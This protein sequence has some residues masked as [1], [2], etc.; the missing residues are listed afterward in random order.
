MKKW[1]IFASIILSLI[2]LFL[3]VYPNIEIQT[4]DQLIAFRYSDDIDEFETDITDD[5]CYVYY[6]KRDISIFNYD[7][8]KFWFF[9]VITMDYVK[10]NMCEKEYVLEEEYIQKFIENAVIEENEANIDVAELIKGKKAIV[11]NTRYSGNEYDQSIWYVLDGREEV[12]YVF[13]V[14]DMVVFQV[15]LS[16]EGPKFIAYK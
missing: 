6:G 15:G 7:F 4:D 3:I 9:H 2:V 12:M 5:E 10:G 16:D 1:I 14:D 13:Y 8:K 11:G